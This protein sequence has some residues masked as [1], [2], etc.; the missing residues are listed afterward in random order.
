MG[1]NGGNQKAITGRRMA[2]REPS[3]AAGVEDVET[4]DIDIHHPTNRECRPRGEARAGRIARSREVDSGVGYFL[5]H[6]PNRRCSSA[7]VPGCDGRRHTRVRHG[8]SLSSRHTLN[9]RGTADAV[10]TNR[11]RASSARFRLRTLPRP[12][13]PSRSGGRAR[14]RAAPAALLPSVAC[15]YAATSGAGSDPQ[16]CSRSLSNVATPGGQPRRLPLRVLA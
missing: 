9:R 2:S 14:D 13:C 4:I 15:G 7:K 12:P 10:A 11:S 16:L 1:V 8:G 6:L 3:C 5:G